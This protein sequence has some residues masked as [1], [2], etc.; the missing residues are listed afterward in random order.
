MLACVVVL[1]LRVGVVVVCCVVCGCVCFVLFC[2]VYACC[3]YAFLVCVGV[4]VFYSN[5]VLLL[6][7]G[8]GVI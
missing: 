2:C 8:F 6:R 4:V 7:V 5:F 3:G 1:M